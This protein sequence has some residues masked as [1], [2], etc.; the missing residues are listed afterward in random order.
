MNQVNLIGRL[1][2]DI[3]VRYT[4]SG[5]AVGS[6]SIAVNRRFKS[7][8]GERQ[9]DFINFVIWDKAAENLANFTHKGSQVGLGG[10]WQTRNYENN[11][12]QKVYVNELVVNAFDLLDP[13]A[14]TQTQSNLDNVDP[15]AGQNTKHSPN[16]FAASGKTEMDISDDDLPF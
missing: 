14:A 13:K 9:A 12:G 6:G 11:S 1:S 5:K 3:E 15:F 16:P 4:Q 2:K 8:N 10:E 7:A